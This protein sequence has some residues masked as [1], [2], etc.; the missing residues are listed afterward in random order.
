MDSESDKMSDLMPPAF[1]MVDVCVY[2]CL[3][4]PYVDTVNANCRAGITSGNV[5]IKVYFEGS[6]LGLTITDRDGLVG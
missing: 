2:S 4:C 5:A 1:H 6:F 3:T